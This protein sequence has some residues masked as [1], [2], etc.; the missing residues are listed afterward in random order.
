MR[1]ALL[2][3]V[4]L[5]PVL[6]NRQQVLQFVQFSLGSLNR[7]RLVALYLDSKCRLLRIERIAD[8]S[9]ADTAVNITSIIHRGLD[10]GA[11]GF[12]L[13]HN[14]PSGDATPSEADVRVTER[15]GWIAKELDMH[16]VDHLIVAHGNVSS[17][18]WTK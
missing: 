10:V 7:E 16:L 12:L 8:G 17:V 5:G 13:V 4:Q 18:L 9:V 11:S 1:T 15:L 3:S 6:S 14:H 2:E